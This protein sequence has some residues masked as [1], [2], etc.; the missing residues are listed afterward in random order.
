[1]IHWIFYLHCWF[2]FKFGANI[3]FYFNFS[4]RATKFDLLSDIFDFS[5]GISRI[6]G[7]G[8]TKF[9][10]RKTVIFS[11]EISFKNFESKLLNNE[12]LLKCKSIEYL[13]MKKPFIPT[14]SHLLIPIEFIIISCLNIIFSA[15]FELILFQNLID[16]WSFSCTNFE[17]FF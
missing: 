12:F 15:F 17:N 1:M 16:P 10:N 6:H 13:K 11:Y 5:G 8:G 9:S 2:F 4:K 14:Y 3:H 7:F